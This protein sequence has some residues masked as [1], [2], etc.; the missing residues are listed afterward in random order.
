M[1]EYHVGGGY[2]VDGAVED[3][4]AD[5]A[6]KFQIMSIPALLIFK[7]GK[8]AKQIIGLTQA[9]ELKKALQ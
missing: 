9:D 7:D 4:E 3:V 5:I 6:V 8:L 1:V 2:G